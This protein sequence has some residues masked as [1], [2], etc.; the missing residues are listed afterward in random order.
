M[1]R[2][3]T[4]L[5]LLSMLVLSGLSGAVGA[6][7]SLETGDI[8]TYD[9]D[10]GAVS[11]SALVEA[12]RQIRVPLLFGNVLKSDVEGYTQLHLEGAT[13]YLLSPGAPALPLWSDILT[14][15]VGSHVLDVSIENAQYYLFSTEET[16]VPAPEPLPI[17][18]GYEPGPLYEGSE[19]STN[20]LFPV[21]E[22]ESRVTTGREGRDIVAH[23]FVQVFPMRYNPVTGQ[24]VLLEE[25]EVVVRYVPPQVDVLAGRDANETYD[26]L[27]LVPDEWVNETNR[28]KVHKEAMGWR[29]KVVSLDNVY[30]DSI[31][32]TSDGRD[33]PERI[34]YFIKQAIEN[35]TVE[36]LLVIGDHD[37][38]P[39]R[40]VRV[41]RT[42]R[43]RIETPLSGCRPTRL[44]R[45]LQPNPHDTA[46]ARL[47]H[48]HAIDPICRLDGPCV[49]RDDDE[50]CLVLELLQEPNEPVDV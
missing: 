34:K 6:G 45:I 28:Y 9:E 41:R 27:V 26:V 3:L 49:V 20:T 31:F 14:V 13:G 19:Y 4:A 47:L 22:I 8:G 24:L 18:T 10:E 38:F 50:L 48:R 2:S 40:R 21:K 37:K 36:H 15:P 42:G 23:V 44:K 17:M 46:H 39:I 1:R 12:V 29:I 43:C 11:G 16:I 32:N 5:V 30:D 33:D 35:W 25:A 7:P